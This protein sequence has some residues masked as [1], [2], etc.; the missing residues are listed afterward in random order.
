MNE[1]IKIEKRQDIDK[2]YG[3]LYDLQKKNQK[4]G[5]LY[6]DKM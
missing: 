1:L 4:E 5:I 3:D 2:I 6:Y